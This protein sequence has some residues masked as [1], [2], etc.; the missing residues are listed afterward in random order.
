MLLYGPAVTV[1]L[2]SLMQK[3]RLSTPTVSLAALL[4]GKRPA[5]SGACPTRLEDYVGEIVYS[6]FPGLR[7]SSGRALRGHL[8]GYLRHIV[9][10]DFAELGHNVRNPAAL[11]RWMTAYAAASSTTASF[12]T[13][14]DAATGGHGEKPAKTTTFPYRDVLERL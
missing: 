3:G 11:R 2:A 10:R 8:D 12:E 13:I 14:R 7:F 9:D 1:R 6:G 4:Q 5:L